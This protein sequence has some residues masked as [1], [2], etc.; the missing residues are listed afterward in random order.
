MSGYQ[1]VFH[2]EHA[3]AGGLNMLRDSMRDM[4]STVIRG[5]GGSVP[6]TRGRPHTNEAPAR[7][8]AAPHPRPQ[9]RLKRNPP[10]RPRAG[11]LGAI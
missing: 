5:E 1:H 7:A 2:A 3:L 6:R 9:P 4:F 10:R 11:L 8:G